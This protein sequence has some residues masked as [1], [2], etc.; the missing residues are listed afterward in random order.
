MIDDK[1]T[2]TKSGYKKKE[3]ATVIISSAF[4]IT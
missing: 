1:E 3:A 2:I 4:F